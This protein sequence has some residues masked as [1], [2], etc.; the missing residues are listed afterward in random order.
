MDADE[1]RQVGAT[2]K[3]LGSG[4]HVAFD[5]LSMTEEAGRRIFEQSASGKEKAL[6]P[7]HDDEGWIELC[8]HLQMSRSRLT[9]DQ[10]VGVCV[11]YEDDDRAAVQWKPGGASSAICGNHIMR[12]GKHWAT[13]VVCEE[14]FGE[15]LPFGVIRPLLGWG[16]RRLQL[17]H[18]SNPKFRDDLRRERTSRWEGD[19]HFCLFY[20]YLSGECWYS[21]W[22]GVTNRRSSHFNISR[23][24]NIG[25]GDSWS[26]RMK[27]FGMLLDLDSGTLSV[28]QNGQR[29]G[30]LKDGLAGV[31]CWTA[32]LAGWG[33]VSIERGYGVIDA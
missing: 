22:E 19:V 24:D 15:Y 32:C 20:H 17:F 33:S 12:V 26:R 27:T 10:L 18:P 5:G 25:P 4:G 6:L 31:Y 2:C 7:R 1:L 23:G 30:T 16:Q 21:D 13:F 28:Y 29:V 11:K 14:E 3:A 8:H 9:F